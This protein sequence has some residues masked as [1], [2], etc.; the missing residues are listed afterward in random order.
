MEWGSWQSKRR[1]TLTCVLQYRL[2]EM[3]ASMYDESSS[4]GELENWLARMKTPEDWAAFARSRSCFTGKTCGGSSYTPPHQLIFKPGPGCKA[5]QI[6]IEGFARWG[7]ENTTLILAAHVEKSAR[8]S[9]HVGPC[10]HY[11]T[12]VIRGDPWMNTMLFWNSADSSSTCRYLYRPHAANQLEKEH[13]HAIESH[14]P[15]GGWSVCM[16]QH[17]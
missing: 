17:T 1:Q 2:M 10:T 16:D 12:F 7:S 8:S 14:P 13:T 11:L 4:L 5:V 3:A 6:L 15:T 9:K